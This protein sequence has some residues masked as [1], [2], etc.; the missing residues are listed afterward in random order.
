M[1]GEKVAIVTAGGSGMGAAIVR[2]LAGRG[3]R[4]AVM[5]PSGRV[6]GGITRSV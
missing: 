4:V 5:S 2:E 1:S 6:D 3:Y